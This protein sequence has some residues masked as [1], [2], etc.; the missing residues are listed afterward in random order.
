MLGAI[1]G[2]GTQLRNGTDA[3][4]RARVAGLAQLNRPRAVVVAGMGGS[5]AAGD[6][7]AVAVADGTVPVVVHRGYGLPPWVGGADLVAAVSCSGATEET[8]SAVAEA[9]RRGLNLV[10]VGAADSALAAACAHAG[11]LHLDVEAAGRAPRACLWTLAGPLLCAGEALGLLSAPVEQAAA[12]AEALDACARRCAPAIASAENPAKSLARR[13]VDGLPMVWGFS[14]VAA[15]AARRFG[16]QLAENAKLPAVVGALSEP[17]HNQVV[18]FAAASA[19]G[20]A[21]RIRLL[22]LRDSVEDPRLARRATESRHLAE[23]VGLTVAEIQAEGEQ[24]LVRLAGLTGLLDFTSVY[25]A[26]ALGVDPTPV[27]PIVVLKD[28]L[29]ADPAE[30]GAT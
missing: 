2:A 10:T 27:A 28:R 7:L 14:E 5:A 4:T 26:L 15:A 19:G 23:E 9:G 3:A 18:S 12:A 16:N 24:P 1:A 21:G 13:L 22:V 17:H 6:V 11:G 20:L 30:R 8:L 25:L 29:A